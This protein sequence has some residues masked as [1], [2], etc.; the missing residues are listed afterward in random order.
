MNSKRISQNLFWKKSGSSYIQGRP[1]FGSIR[2]IPCSTGMSWVKPHRGLLESVICPLL[3]CICISGNRHHN[4]R[5]SSDKTHPED[6]QMTGF[7]HSKSRQQCCNGR[8]LYSQHRRFD[9]KKYKL[10]RLWKRIL[11]HG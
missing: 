11:I 10:Q 4:S 3:F 9:R 1:I 2:Q 5:M 7:N 6:G 8:I